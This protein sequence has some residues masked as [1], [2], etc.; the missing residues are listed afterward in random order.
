MIARAFTWIASLV[1]VAVLATGAD[2]F[3]G[4]APHTT[5][6]IS[7]D[8]FRASYL[9]RG[10]TP[11]LTALAA[12]GVRSALR[13]SFP[14]VTFPNHFTLITGLYPDHHGIV[15]NHFEDHVLGRVWD[16]SDVK[17]ASDPVWW[18]GGVS[19]WT[20]AM[21]QGVTPAVQF[22]PAWPI[23]PKPELFAEFNPKTSMAAEAANMLSWLDLPPDR[24]PRLILGYFYPVDHAGHQFGPASPDT[25]RTIAEAD[26]AIG[27]LVEGLKARGVYDDTNIIIVADH[28]MAETSKDRAVP[29]D[30]YIDL[31]SIRVITSG[32]LAGLEPSPGAGT[33][34]AAALL[35]RRGHMTCWRKSA[36]PARFHYGTNPRIPP[37]LCLADVGWTIG[38]KAGLARGVERGSHGYDPDAPE[39][40]AVFVAHGPN[41]RRAMAWPKF[42][43]VDIYPMLAA[44]VGVRP[45]PNDGRLS[46]VAGML[47]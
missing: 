30:D 39:M 40:A 2:A 19:I 44:I 21:A 42:D 38:T 13:P 1:A 20:T 32:P 4:P 6:M 33:R 11:N 26:A 23:G 43:N 9:D 41:F 35:G 18:K 27:N 31:Q 22:W 8:G 36:M 5:I 25:M 24:R 14:S 16:A 7:I 3:A 47:K 28:G 29:L 37:I 17:G 34:V 45:E 10:V 12:D 46:E 15:D